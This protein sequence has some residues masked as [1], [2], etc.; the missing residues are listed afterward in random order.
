MPPPFFLFFLLPLFI[1]PHFLPPPLFCEAVFFISPI[2]LSR[3]RTREVRVSAR[4]RADKSESGCILQVLFVGM[5]AMAVCQCSRRVRCV[6]PR[7]FPAASA[8]II[9][10]TRR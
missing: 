1:F 2:P 7:V 8:P 5:G 4:I 10:S 6:F 9:W 3:R